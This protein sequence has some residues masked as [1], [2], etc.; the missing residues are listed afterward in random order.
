M[1]NSYISKLYVQVTHNNIIIKV[2]SVSMSF[3]LESD[4]LQIK[5]T[6]DDLRYTPQCIHEAIAINSSYDLCFEVH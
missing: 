5:V 2:S 6:E 1:Q 4:H 3:L